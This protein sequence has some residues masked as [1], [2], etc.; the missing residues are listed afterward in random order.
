[1]SGY[2]EIVV[3]DYFEYLVVVG[4]DFKVFIFLKVAFFVFAFVLVMLVKVKIVPIG[5]WSPVEASRH[6][7]PKRQLR[8]MK[9]ARSFNERL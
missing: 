4:S 3:S 2:Y 7:W 8:R 5:S 9:K 1:M 6:W